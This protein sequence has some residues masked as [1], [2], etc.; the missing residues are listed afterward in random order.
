MSDPKRIGELNG[1]WS[2][3][4]R[5]ALAT[6][7]LLLLWG[8]WVTM[9]MMQIQYTYFSRAEFIELEHRIESSVREHADH[10]HPPKWVID[11]LERHEKK[12][13]P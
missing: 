1:P 2:L 6:Y 7:P 9:T 12:I 11:I 4:L 3:L 8:A 10:G 13:N 5:I